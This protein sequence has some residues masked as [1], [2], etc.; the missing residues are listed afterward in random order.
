MRESFS[1]TQH[2]IV[3]IHTHQQGKMF[4]LQGTIIRLLYKNRS[5]YRGLMMAPCSWNMLS[6]WYVCIL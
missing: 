4:Q 1:L 3:K 2:F 6:C 5:L